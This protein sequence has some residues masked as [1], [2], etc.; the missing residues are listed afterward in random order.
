M[1]NLQEV[2]INARILKALLETLFKKSF[3]M[4]LLTDPVVLFQ[5]SIEPLQGKKV[6]HNGVKVELLGQIGMFFASM[7]QCS[8]LSLIC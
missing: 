1:K 6:D 8:A 4:H 7:F 2:V 5:I 3:S